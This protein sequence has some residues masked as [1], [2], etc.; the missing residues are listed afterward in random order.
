MKDISFKSQQNA[1]IRRTLNLEEFMMNYASPY[2]LKNNE[3]KVI[4]VNDK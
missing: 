3:F 4:S 1:I 2:D